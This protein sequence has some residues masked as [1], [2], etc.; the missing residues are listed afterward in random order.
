MPGV[1]QLVHGLS[2]SAFR[3]RSESSTGQLYDCSK[4]TEETSQG[5]GSSKRCLSG[6]FARTLEYIFR[7]ARSEPRKFFYLLVDREG[8]YRMLASQ[9]SPSYTISIYQARIDSS[10]TGNRLVWLVC[11]HTRCLG[12]NV[13]RCRKLSIQGGRLSL[14]ALVA[15][16]QQHKLLGEGR[17]PSAAAA[18]AD[19]KHKMTSTT[20]L[21]W[22]SSER[23]RLPA[24]DF[25][26]HA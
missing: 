13:A 3:K 12:I 19:R 11:V 24:K 4:S 8:R 10:T 22:Q 14:L 9:A 20:R 25:L 5:E 21:S 1:V 7:R 26:R 2:Q 6:I 15:Y 23:R 16:Q 17:P 18:A